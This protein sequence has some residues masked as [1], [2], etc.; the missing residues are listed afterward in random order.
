MQRIVRL[1]P[2]A[3]GHEQELFV[4]YKSALMAVIHGAFGWDEAFQRERFETCYERDWFYWIEIN[5]SR[6]GYIC[7]WSKASEMH[8]SLL[9][10]DDAERGRGYG[11][12]AMEYVHAM[13]RQQGCRI[14]LSSFRENVSAIKFYEKLGYA[15]VGGDEHFIDMELGAP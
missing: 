7:Y 3:S 8:V 5:G 15:I 10:V 13:A 12:N 9:I 6:I 11:R 2:V 1:T 14:T 4:R